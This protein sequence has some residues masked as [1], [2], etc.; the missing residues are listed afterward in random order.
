MRRLAIGYSPSDI[1]RPT[2]VETDRGLLT[3]VRGEPPRLVAE[4]FEGIADPGESRYFD[5]VLDTFSASHFIR[6]VVEGP[7]Q[8]EQLV[9]SML[10]QEL[11]WDALPRPRRTAQPPVPA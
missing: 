9:S 7:E 11:A 5:V 3:F 6:D 4:P 2:L 10:T 1:E 8:L